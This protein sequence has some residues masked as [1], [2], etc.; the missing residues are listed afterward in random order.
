MYTAAVVRLERLGQGGELG[1]AKFPRQ[2]SVD[3]PFLR[4]LDAPLSRRQFIHRLSALTGAAVVVPGLMLE[5]C[6][7]PSSTGQTGGLVPKAG[8]ILKAA[9]TGEPDSLDPAIGTNYVTW[10][11]FGNIF[12][13]LVEIQSD[14][15]FTGVLAKSWKTPD[16]N[17]YIFDLRD[18]VYF[19]N[20]E[21]FT[22]ND[23][24]YSIDRVL[25]PKKGSFAAPLIN[26]IT[27]VE[28]SSPTEVVLHLKN[29]FGPFFINLAQHL[30][31]VNQKAIES[32]DP[33]RNPVGTGPFKF[34]EWVQG[35]HLT[36]AKNGKYFISNRPYLDQV[37]FEFRQVDESRILALR[38]GDLNWLDGVPLQDIGTLKSDSAFNFITSA[39]IGIPD[40]IR[41]QT[42]KP[43]FNNKAL[44]QAVAWAIDRKAVRD[45][46]Y[47]GTGQ[48]GAEEFGSGS[49]WSDGVD[50]YPGSPDVNQAKAKLAQAG[51]SGGLQVEC[52]TISTFPNYVK[53]A[54]VVQQ[55]LKA[56]GIDMKITQL[57]ASEWLARYSGGNFQ[58]LTGSYTG[59]SDPDVFWSFETAPGNWNHYSN[60]AVDNLIQQARAS[61]DFATRKSLYAQ[62][63]KIIAEDV[64]I[65]FVHY[66]SIQYLMAK[67]VVG[68]TTNL[69]LSIRLENVGISG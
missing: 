42:A 26:T 41:F 5:A 32:S 56:I 25:D 52:I 10:E 22:A 14:G 31:I 67:N 39:A 63:R 4:L 38:S 34:V 30:Q 44:R 59:I 65:I 28:V 36:I 57:G 50:P 9:V 46:A 55:N 3:F 48:L 15:K 35:D 45:V 54:L 51:V 13:T 18:D 1:M 61:A 23:V 27:G 19:H 24:K 17:T 43:P 49:P 37:I 11:I 40:Q 12:S 60:P 69:D 2:T 64:P 20:G 16:P 6:A 68:S 53:T 8:G 47:F 21:K 58:M 29:P 7:S 62:V 66:E 33:A